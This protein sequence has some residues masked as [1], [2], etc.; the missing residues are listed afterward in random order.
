[1]V[2]YLQIHDGADSGESVGKDPKQSAI[3][4]AGVR[5]CLDCV[6]KL[7]DFTFDECRC[8]AFGP[9]KLLALPNGP[10]RRPYLSTVIAGCWSRSSSN[11]TA[12]IR[13]TSLSVILCLVIELAE[14]MNL[15]I[16]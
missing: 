4:E 3:A 5:G 9:R 13:S 1:M 14:D 16:V 6:E 11:V 7:L 8:F 10:C 2:F 15:R 12:G